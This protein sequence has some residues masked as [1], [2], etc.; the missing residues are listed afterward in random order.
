MEWKSR[1]GESG[2]YIEKTPDGA[3]KLIHVESGSIEWT[4]SLGLGGGHMVAVSP[5]RKRAYVA[6]HVT[7]MLSV[8]DL[9]TDEVIDELV[10]SVQA[11]V[12]GLAD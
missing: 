1:P 6:H 4:V 5:D 8:I 2:M 11:V 9:A 3:I 10:G 7:P 12:V